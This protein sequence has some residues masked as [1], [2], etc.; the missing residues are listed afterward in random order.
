MNHPYSEL[1]AEYESWVA[2]CRTLPNRA[3]EVDHVARGLIREGAVEQFLAVQQQIGVP[4]VVQAAI[5]HREYGETGAM[6]NRN[7]G[8]GDPLTRPSMHVPR[9]RPPLG[10]APNDRFPVSWVYAAIDAFTVCDKLNVISV[11][12]WSLPYACFK[13][14]FYNGG[15]Y[16][17]RGLRSPYV[18]GGTNLQQDGKYVADGDWDP[19]H[20]DEQLGTLPIMLR[21]IELL[22]D[23]ALGA[24]I[25]ASPASIVKIP[26]SIAALP[27]ALG[28][29]LTGTKWVQASLNVT[30]GLAHPLDVDGSFGR[31]TR[32]AVRAFQVEHGLANQTGFVD[33]AFCTAMDAALAAA[34]PST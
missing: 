3:D 31:Q 33:D 15:G 6:F 16:R 8:Q 2:N 24:P 22:P 7:P 19:D 1:A 21:M 9:G 23:L 29:S 30:E 28:G 10:A 5:C 11:P 14:E 25:S 13:E 4:A 26:T 32:A 34:R 17:A 12:S 18:V 20:M 27:A